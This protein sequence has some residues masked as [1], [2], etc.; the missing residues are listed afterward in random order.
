MMNRVYVVKCQDYE[1]VPD[2]MEELLNMMGGMDRFVKKGEVVM[3]DKRMLL[4]KSW[5]ENHAVKR[6]QTV[7]NATNG[8]L[9]IEGIKNKSLEDL[10]KK[11]RKRNS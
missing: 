4:Y 9:N 2:M 5:F 8:G 1:Q 11:I 6:M 10:E 7:I 3:T